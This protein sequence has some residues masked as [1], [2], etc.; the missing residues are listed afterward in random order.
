MRLAGCVINDIADRRLDGHVTRTAAG[1]WPRAGSAP[2]PLVLFTAL[3]GSAA[4]LFFLNPLTRWLAVAG[5]GI[6]AS[7]RS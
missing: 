1:R 6:A 3:S 7:T 4:L 2:K 5:L